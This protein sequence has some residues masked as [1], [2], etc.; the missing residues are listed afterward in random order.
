MSPLAV[1]AQIH[2]VALGKRAALPSLEGVLI[3]NSGRC[4]SNDGGEKVRPRPFLPLL[5]PIL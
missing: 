3:E 5:P 1:R 2:A 4:S